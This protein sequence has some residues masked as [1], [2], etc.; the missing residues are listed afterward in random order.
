[1]DIHRRNFGQK[2]NWDLSNLIVEEDRTKT[3]KAAL[4]LEK[5]GTGF[6]NLNT[7]CARKTERPYGSSGLLRLSRFL[8]VRVF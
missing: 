3:L 7:G 8:L 5:P 2:E 4:S 6:L 1:M